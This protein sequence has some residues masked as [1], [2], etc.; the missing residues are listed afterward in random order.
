MKQWQVTNLRTG[1]IR[2][3]RAVDAHDACVRLGWWRGNC[4]A[5][6]LDEQGQP[7][8]SALLRQRALMA[9]SGAPE[10]RN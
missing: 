1:Q 3:V 5:L 7:K 4:A 9:S 2:K 8:V 10:R 6:E